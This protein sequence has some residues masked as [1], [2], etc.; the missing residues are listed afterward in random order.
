MKPVESAV[1]TGYLTWYKDLEVKLY[2]STVDH[3]LLSS[4]VSEPTYLLRQHLQ[5]YQEQHLPE[6]LEVPNAWGH[7]AL[8]KSIAVRYG[9]EEQRI[10]TANGVSNGIYLLCRALLASNDHVVIESPVY[11]PL[12]A[13][14]DIVGSRITYVTRKPPQYLIDPDDLR[15]AVRSDTALLLISN[16]H[17]PSGALLTDEQ[18]ME[19]ASV[20]QRINP[21]IRIAVDE[22]YH[23][24][25]H[26]AQAPAATLGDCFISLNGLTKVYGLGCLHT[27]WILAEPSIIDKIK[28]VRLVVEGSGAKLLEGL[29][30]FIIEN[31][32]TYL[33]RAMKLVSVNRQ[34]LSQFLSPIV[35]DGLLSGDIPRY[36]CIFF[37]EV[38][39]RND[40]GTL[41]RELA[42]KHLVH[43]VPG[44]F[45]GSPGHI[46]IGFGGHTE[47]LQT[48]LEKL[49]HGLYLLIKQVDNS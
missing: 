22:V 26:G 23:D 32:D 46:R 37:P 49:A 6:R 2:G 30:S 17:N 39:R 25:A 8:I 19:L 40:T 15:R 10:A 7:P 34:V 12:V 4:A 44:D 45:F 43:V 33:D 27:G 21:A 14:V 36:G 41:S 35:K 13:A 9:V 3:V 11:D 24:F 1:T 20:A 31:L 48:S 38:T 47:K 18:L 28:R 29:A 5:Q 42:E 16:L